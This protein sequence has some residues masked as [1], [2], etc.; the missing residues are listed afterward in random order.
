MGL[1]LSSKFRWSVLGSIVL[2]SADS[3]AEK[4]VDFILLQ[5]SPV[6]VDLGMQMR[7]RC[8]T[9]LQ[10]QLDPYIVHEALEVGGTRVLGS[11]VHRALPVFNASWKGIK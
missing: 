7:R 6:D 11:N 4:K 1:S 3:Q 5:G 9:R 10:Y 8:N 2:S